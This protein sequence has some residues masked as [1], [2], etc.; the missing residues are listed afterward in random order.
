M[1]SKT[2][3]FFLTLRTFFDS[4]VNFSWKIK[5]NYLLFCWVISQSSHNERYFGKRYRVWY[6]SRFHRF[7]ALTVNEKYKCHPWNWRNT[8][9]FV[10]YL[11]TSSIS[12]IELKRQMNFE[13]VWSNL[14]RVTWKISRGQYIKNWKHNSD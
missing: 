13:I 6:I 7:D 12:C 2:S 3:W 8:A 10:H 5:S 9:I 11:S 4:T 1:F 14:V